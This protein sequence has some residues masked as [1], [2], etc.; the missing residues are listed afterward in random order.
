MKKTLMRILILC[1][2]CLLLCSCGKKNAAAD[3]TTQPATAAPTGEELPTDETQ[4]TGEATGTEPTTGTEPSQNTDPSQSTEPTQQAPATE[5]TQPTEELEY[6]EDLG[7]LEEELYYDEMPEIG[8]G[9]LITVKLETYE[10]MSDAEKQAYEA[11]F[12]NEYAFDEWMQMA[13]MDYET[14]LND[15]VLMGFGTLNL[16]EIIESLIGQEIA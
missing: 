4:Q 8:T 2:V 5:Q 11:C 15:D 14:S 13:L 12:S 3:G 7:Y 9:P 10:N 1:M 6:T 16:K